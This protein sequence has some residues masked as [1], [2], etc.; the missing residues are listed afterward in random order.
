[1]TCKQD[2]INI[3]IAL[4]VVALREK[5]LN[6]LRTFIYLKTI[7]SGHYRY[8]SNFVLRHSTFL[9]VHPRTF[10]NHLK[11]LIKL[12]WITINNKSKNHRVVSFRQ[13]SGKYRFPSA[14]GA[15][16]YFEDIDRFK[17]FCI[18][19]VAMYYIEWIGRILAIR[20]GM[21]LFKSRSL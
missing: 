2:Y 8:D 6:V 17:G 4:M 20:P 21:S 11:Q 13:L 12:S 14:K 1:M 16:F 15:I 3:P 19:A 5:K 7:C 9:K 18:A 10:R